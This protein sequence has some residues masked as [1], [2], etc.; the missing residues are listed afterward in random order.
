MLGR[1]RSTVVTAG[2][3]QEMPRGEMIA[4]EAGEMGKMLEQAMPRGEMT[5]SEA[6]ATGNML[7][8]EMPR[9][10]MTTSEAGAMGNMPGAIELPGLWR[11]T[12]S[13]V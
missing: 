1:P 13:P 4:S 3:M 2:K 7:G 6:G 5:T 8:Q 12:I 9:G 11:L 10:E